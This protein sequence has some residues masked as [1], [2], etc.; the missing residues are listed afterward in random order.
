MTALL[1]RLKQSVVLFCLQRASVTLLW[2]HKQQ[3][4]RQTVHSADCGRNLKICEWDK[5]Q[6]HVLIAQQC[7]PE[8]LGCLPALAQRGAGEASPRLFAPRGGEGFV[9]SQFPLTTFQAD[10]WDFPSA[11]PKI[12]VLITGLRRAQG[13]S[14]SLLS[15]MCLTNQK[16]RLWGSHVLCWT[17]AW[18]DGPRLVVQEIFLTS[19]GSRCG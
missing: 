6:V 3:I 1:K 12:T 2:K 9:C 8:A 14:C 16:H 18:A 7:Y 17:E 13:W 15:S 4:K 10:T 5:W 19:K 11:W